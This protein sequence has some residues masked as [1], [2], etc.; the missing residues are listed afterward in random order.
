MHDMTTL[1][2]IHPAAI[3]RP[4]RLGTVIALYRS[5]RALT[6]LDTDALFDIGVTAAQAH[7]EA[8][9][10]FWDLPTAWRRARR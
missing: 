4:L 3:S 10:A 9:R 2:H 8:Q 1:A 6:A 7:A 5:R